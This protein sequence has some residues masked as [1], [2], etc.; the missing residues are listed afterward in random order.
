MNEHGQRLTT[1][2]RGCWSQYGIETGVAGGGRDG[3]GGGIVI[4]HQVCLAHLQMRT[5]LFVGEIEDLKVDRDP[6]DTATNLEG[7][8]T[9][10]DEVAQEFSPRTLLAVGGIPDTRFAGPVAT[11]RP[12]SGVATR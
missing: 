12:R 8:D 11:A 10:I 2:Q 5:G 7:I 1:G 4:R 9:V 6:T 3:L